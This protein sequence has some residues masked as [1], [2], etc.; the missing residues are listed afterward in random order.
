MTIIV[1][2]LFVAAAASIVV[3]AVGSLLAFL[4]G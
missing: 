2:F 3:F 4:R 1:D